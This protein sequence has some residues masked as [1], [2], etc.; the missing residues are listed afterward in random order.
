MKNVISD[1]ENKIIEDALTQSIGQEDNLSFEFIKV[2][3]SKFNKKSR[4]EDFSH[5]YSGEEE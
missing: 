5:N 3:E 2:Y 1:T 4:M